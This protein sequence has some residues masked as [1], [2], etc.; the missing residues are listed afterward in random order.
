MEITPGG[1]EIKLADACDLLKKWAEE[2]RLIQVQFYDKQADQASATFVGRIELL[3]DTQCLRIDASSVIAKP[4]GDKYGCELNLAKARFWLG[5][6]R[7]IGPGRDVLKAALARNFEM[8]LVVFY[9]S[10]FTCELYIVKT[11][12]EVADF[13]RG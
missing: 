4:Y 11:A 12:L 5:D 3:D 10:G 1:V 2:R 7:S 13:L 8:F 9:E 6:D